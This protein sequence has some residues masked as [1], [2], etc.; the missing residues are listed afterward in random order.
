MDEVMVDSEDKVSPSSLGCFLPYKTQ[1]NVA[2]QK[3]HEIL[4]KK[5][6]YSFY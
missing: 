3:F 1:N 4:A 2:S 5:N 6:A